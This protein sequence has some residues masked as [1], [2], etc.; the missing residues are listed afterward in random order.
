MLN[1]ELS[2]LKAQDM[3]KNHDR[4][5]RLEK[6]IKTE[7]IEKEAQ[8]AETVQ[9]LKQSREMLVNMRFQN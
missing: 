1:A 4:A 9:K 7:I 6:R 2:K 5:K 3:S 8:N